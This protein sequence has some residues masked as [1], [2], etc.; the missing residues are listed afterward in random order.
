MMTKPRPQGYVWVTRMSMASRLRASASRA[1][2]VRKAQVRGTA[3]E[4]AKV[5]YSTVHARRMGAAERMQPWVTRQ[6]EDDLEAVCA[7]TES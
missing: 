4:E 5:L 7:G 6:R 1:C 2:A 3:D